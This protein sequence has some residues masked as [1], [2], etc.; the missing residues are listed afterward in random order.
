LFRAA[1]LNA[2]GQYLLGLVDGGTWVAPGL[3]WSLAA[4]LF[5]ILLQALEYNVHRRRVAR[6]LCSL[7]GTVSGALLLLAGFVGVLS[8]KISIDARAIATTGQAQP[9]ASFI[10]FRF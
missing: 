10:Y 1:S 2:A 7:R 5:A 8:L 9:P 4:M 6:V 3:P